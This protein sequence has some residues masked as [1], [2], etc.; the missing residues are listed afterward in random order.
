MEKTA[1]IECNEPSVF[2]IN[3]E[4]NSGLFGV[5]IGIFSIVKRF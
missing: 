5:K 4:S 2:F 1:G 3:K